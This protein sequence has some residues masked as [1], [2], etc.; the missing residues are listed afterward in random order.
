VRELPPRPAMTPRA[1]HLAG[2]VRMLSSTPSVRR[3]LVDEIQ[4][5]V[6][7]G[8][9]VTEEKLDLAIGRMLEDILR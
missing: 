7:A 3:E 2:I 8:D 6:E 4:R 9:Y 1:R 5:Q